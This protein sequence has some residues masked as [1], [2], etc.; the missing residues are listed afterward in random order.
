M[1]R[2][3]KPPFNDIVVFFLPLFWRS[4]IKP[5]M[6]FKCGFLHLQFV[7]ETIHH[8]LDVWQTIVFKWLFSYLR[9]TVI[10]FSYAIKSMSMCLETLLE[11][12]IKLDSPFTN[13]FHDT[14]LD[15]NCDQFVEQTAFLCL[16][17]GSQA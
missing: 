11:V 7:K 8:L 2:T 15:G 1:L 9:N 10:F 5:Y 14:S 17:Y 3:K 12:T 16:L 4:L 13:P 6:V